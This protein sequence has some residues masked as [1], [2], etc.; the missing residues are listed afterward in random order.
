M[1]IFQQ[2]AGYSL[3]GADMVRRAI[4]KK[5][6]KQIEAERAAF[7]YGDPERGIKGCIANGIPEETAQA[8]YNEI[9]DFANYAFNKAHAVCYA[10]VAYQTAY[11]KCY[12]PREY[13]AALITSVLDSTGKVAEYITECKE[14]KIP[15][16][17]PDVNE[18]GS[19]F[20]VV[21]GGIRFGMVGIKG[22]GRGL[23]DALVT[24]R[25]ANGPYKNFR[26]FCDR[27]FDHDLNR[28]ALENM[29]RC[30]SFDSMGVRRSQLIAVMNPV[31]DGIAAA[32]KRNLEGQ[33]D[34]FGGFGGDTE[35]AVDEVPLPDIPEFSR[36]ELMRM[37]RETTGLYLTG[38]PMD[39]YRDV[40]RRLRSVSLGAILSD[41]G[42]ED[43]PK[44]FHD[45]QRVILACVVTGVKTKTTRN[46]TMMAY[47]DLEDDTGS[48]EML[49]F[50]RVLGECGSYLQEGNAVVVDGRISVRDEKAP[51][52]MC[53]SV[54]PLAEAG[55]AEASYS[56]GPSTIRGE[57]GA[58]RPGVI[59]GKDKLYLKVPSITD[60]RVAYI[61]KVLV[62]FPGTGKL[63]LYAEDTKKQYGIS[64][65]IHTSLVREMQEVLGAENVV[66]K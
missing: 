21:P 53:N 15:L 14:M 3:G 33:F 57:S 34:L 8:I 23:I 29:I 9:Y 12:Y 17:P 59:P 61:R 20:T 58:A 60:D 26:D 36:A 6:A 66:V 62:M 47:V 42:G 24:E 13:M 48:I 10:I 44:Q 46:N 64:C 25:N 65:L 56:G 37:E 52:I 35:A 2:L 30:G 50:A 27:M 16:M 38:H 39:E 55:P 19:D 43:G 31:M 41:F 49:V 54:R 28:R 45:E 18:S 32:R 22:V 5:K 63:V 40:V 4:S 1:M 11:F 51:Q 7:I